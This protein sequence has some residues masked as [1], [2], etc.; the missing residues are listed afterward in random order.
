MKKIAAN[1]NYRLRKRAYDEY[2]HTLEEC[3]DELELEREKNKILAEGV[4]AETKGSEWYVRYEGD[5][6]GY[7]M[8]VTA[9]FVQA[10]TPGGHRLI[11]VIGG[12]KAIIELSESMSIVAVRTPTAEDEMYR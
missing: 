7:T 9:D 12:K 4:T 8:F 2:N 1:K 5:E 10:E 6:Y 3:E 11:V